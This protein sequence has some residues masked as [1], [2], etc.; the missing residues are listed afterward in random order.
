MNGKLGKKP[1]THDL[2]TLAVSLF[3]VG[4]G[5][6][7]LSRTG[8]ERKYAEIDGLEAS[9]PATWI[10]IAERDDRIR[11]SAIDSGSKTPLSFTVSTY[12]ADDGV[13]VAGDLA[14]EYATSHDAFKLTSFAYESLPGGVALGMDYQFVDRGSDPKSPLSVTYGKDLI[15]PSASGSCV[16]SLR[17]SGVG[18]ADAA[19][20]MAKALAE[21]VIKP[22][23]GGAR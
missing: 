4:L 16:V 14:L 13:Q 22:L 11:L 1:K 15:M 21:I 6:F 10:N 3:A 23:A 19:R 7:F 8:L 9:Y 20:S 17:V 2:A 5:V 12:G 18:A